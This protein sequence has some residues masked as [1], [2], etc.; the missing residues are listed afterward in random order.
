MVAYRPDYTIELL[1][2]EKVDGRP[3]Y[4]LRLRPFGD[5]IV[6]NLREM[7][8]DVETFDLWKATFVGKCGPCSHPTEITFV[9]RPAAGAW[10]VA[11]YSFLSGCGALDP[12][13]CSFEMQ[14]DDIV[15]VPD[16]PDW[17]FDKAAYAA[18]AKAKAPDLLAG[19]F[20]ESRER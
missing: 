19:V 2:V 5:P 17:L 12:S 3:A 9:F 11:Q 7:W 8:A 1:G 16:L 20:A 15:F 4:H 6:H 13:T 14:T 10:I 18:R